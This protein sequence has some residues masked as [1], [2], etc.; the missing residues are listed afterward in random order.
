VVDHRIHEGIAVTYREHELRL[1]EGRDELLDEE[2]EE[3]VRL[4]LETEEFIPLENEIATFALG[5]KTYLFLQ[6]EGDQDAGLRFVFGTVST[7]EDGRDG[8]RAGLRTAHTVRVDA[9]R[10]VMC[11]GLREKQDHPGILQTVSGRFKRE[12]Q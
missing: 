3:V 6:E 1:W 11:T 10:L 2:V 7:M 9:P 4:H 5:N 8:V 12:L